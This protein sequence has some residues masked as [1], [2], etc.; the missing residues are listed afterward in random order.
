M[1]FIFFFFF[2]KDKLVVYIIDPRRVKGTI[3]Y[4]SDREVC[5]NSE[6]PHQTKKPASYQIL[7]CLLPI[8]QLYTHQEV[9]KTNLFT[10]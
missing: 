10:L 8:Q 9:T 2:F 7:N 5:A 3:E 1:T 6:D 4:Y